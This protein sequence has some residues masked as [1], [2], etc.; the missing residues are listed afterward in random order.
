M[1]LSVSDFKQA[2]SKYL[3]DSQ[4]SSFDLKAVL[5]DMDGV[6]FDSMPIHAY[7]WTKALLEMGV[8]FTEEE[9][10][11][12]EGRTGSGTIQLVYRKSLGREA[13]EAE[14]QRIYKRKSQ[15]FEQHPEAPVMPGAKELLDLV[16][17]A[18]LKR[19]LVTGS[20]QKTLLDK[21]NTHFPGH[22]V[23]KNM[24]TAYD[25]TMGKPHP[26]PYL[27][28]LKKAQTQINQAIVV[29]NAPLGVASAKAAGL[30]TVAVKTGKL[31]DHHLLDAGA[32]L[33]FQG[34]PALT[35][36][37]PSLLETFHLYQK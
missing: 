17:Q 23:Q 35:K 27:K 4:L 28:G 3:T 31:Q 24:V 36:A 26:E 21:L 15:L 18:G 29:E 2:I 12:N 6:L 8:D 7:S 14:I 13:G 9:G 25:V 20:G 19:I 30:F 37:W 33:L 10:Y 11:L 32:D 5:F 22:F 16:E 1:P 34:M